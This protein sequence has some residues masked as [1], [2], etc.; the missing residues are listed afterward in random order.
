MNSNKE[1]TKNTAFRQHGHNE[2]K[3]IFT[4]KCVTLITLNTDTQN[5]HI[6]KL[7]GRDNLEDLDVDG[8]VI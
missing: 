8:R 5:W 6:K 1:P 2:Y 4:G 7:K 3:N